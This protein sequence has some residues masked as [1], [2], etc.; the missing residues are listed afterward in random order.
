M[1]IRT[2][3]YLMVG[4]LLGA[5]HL[6]AEILYSVTDLGANSLGN[7]INNAGQVTGRIRTPNGNVHA[8][9]YSNGQMMDLGTLGGTLSNG[10]GINDAGQVV[11]SSGTADGFRHA[12][13]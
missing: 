6:P 3:W 2:L 7:G 13:L 4:L 12:F 5:V 10:Q 8:F 9:L 1:R 11:G